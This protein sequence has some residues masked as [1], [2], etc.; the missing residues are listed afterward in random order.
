[1]GL[2]I[3]FVERES[4]REDNVFYS[5]FKFD[6]QAM[7]QSISDCQVLLNLEELTFEGT[8]SGVIFSPNVTWGDYYESG[9]DQLGYTTPPSGLYAYQN[10]GEYSGI[11]SGTLEPVGWHNPP[12]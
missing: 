3:Y 11:I 12:V 7:N 4:Y 8:I 10:T 9:Y 6:F 5:G 2:G 1:M